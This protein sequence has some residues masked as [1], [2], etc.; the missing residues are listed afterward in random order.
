VQGL[1]RRIGALLVKSRRYAFR[2]VE[3]DSL[4]QYHAALAEHRPTVAIFVYSSFLMPWV[5]AAITPH[6][7]IRVAIPM[8]YEPV[9]QCMEDHAGVFDYL[10]ILDSHLETDNPR[11]FTV[12]RALPPA[13]T[14]KAEAPR[15]PPWIGSFGFAFGHKGF[16]TLAEA[17]NANLDEA[18]YNLH[19]P[20]AAFNGTGDD[21]HT[22]NILDAI[23]RA[24]DKPGVEVRH[25]SDYLSER[26]AVKMLA[27]NDINCLWYH[28]G[29]ANPGLASALDYVIAAQRPIL[30]TDATNFNGFTRPG[31]T[32]PATTF[33][34]I[35]NDY[36]A[37]VRMAEAL[38]AET[39]GRFVG[40][41]EAVVDAVTP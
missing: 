13:V 35:L 25:T 29:Q 9:D 2:Y 18:V 36:P 11:V 39:A 3:C 38:Y 30:L 28:P 7:P 8:N 21:T 22:R 20:E 24:I 40:D 14:R 12:G 17:L 1:G 27:Q 4:E 16:H 41:V 5:P 26:D 34:D 33:R 37:H 10:M 6:P 19:M 15:D 32:Y 23:R 31:M